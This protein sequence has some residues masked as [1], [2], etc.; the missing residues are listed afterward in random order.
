VSV[1]RI[2]GLL[3]PPTLAEKYRPTYQLMCQALSAPLCGYMVHEATKQHPG[4]RC[5]LVILHMGLGICRDFVSQMPCCQ[6]ALREE[7]AMQEQFWTAGGLPALYA[8]VGSA[9]LASDL[10]TFVARNE[11]EV[12][13]SPTLEKA[14]LI[15]ICVG[16][17]G[18]VIED[19]RLRSGTPAEAERARRQQRQRRAT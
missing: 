12:A 13:S 4:E 6:E 10:A 1:N 11:H 2:S 9:R 5:A 3:V 17:A 16:P 18:M 14:Y 8:F 19:L 15:G 7:L